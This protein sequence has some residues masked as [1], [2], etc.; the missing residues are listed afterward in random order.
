[1]GMHTILP[2]LL[3]A[4]TFVQPKLIDQTGH[5]FTFDSLRGSAVALTFVSAHCSDA[6]PLIDAEFAAADAALKKSHTGVRLLTITLDPERD[7]LGDLRKL[8]HTFSAD[9]RT[10]IVAGGTRKDVHEVMNA[11]GV[12]AQ[13][14]PDGYEDAHSTEVFVIDARGVL[15]ATL[16]PSRN[17]PEQITEAVRETG[18][19]R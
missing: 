4:A 2:A 9:P 19:T 18:R 8:A 11:F 5:A 7:S 17:L 6:C 13:R 1:M 10:W 12:I 15:R 14:G 3:L 16:L